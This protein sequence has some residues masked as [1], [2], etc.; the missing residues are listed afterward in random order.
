[1]MMLVFMT[2]NGWIMISVVVGAIIGNYLYG[3]EIN[4]TVACH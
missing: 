1:M 4:D 3:G 2:Y